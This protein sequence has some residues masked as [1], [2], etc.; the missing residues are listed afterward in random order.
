[1]RARVDDDLG[2][3]PLARGEEGFEAD[4]T[5]RDR[6]EVEDAQA[7]AL[8]TADEQLALRRLVAHA[9][10]ASCG[11]HAIDVVVCMHQTT[12]SMALNNGRIDLVDVPT[13][14][15]QLLGLIWRGGKI[16]HPG[17]EHDDWATAV[18]GCLTLV[19][20]L[21]AGFAP[22]VMAVIRRDFTDRRPA[23]TVVDSRGTRYLGDG[24]FR[25]A[26]G[27]LV[28]LVGCC[29]SSSRRHKLVPS[30]SRRA[31]FARFRPFGQSRRTGGTVQSSSFR[32]LS[33]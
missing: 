22:F 1:M 23:G 20:G 3:E 27:D 7:L 18:A 5:P 30:A 9:E 24:H 15:Q 6:D 28:S 8:L 21:G 4:R 25:A 19:S 14:E 16:T 32:S 11:R 29:V 10:R 2:L 17:G 13:L 12:T 31:V 33:R 26:S